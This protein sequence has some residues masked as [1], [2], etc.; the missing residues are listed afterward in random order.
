M[1]MMYTGPLRLVRAFLLSATCVALSLAA[2]LVG[3][4][5]GEPGVPLA[6]ALGLLMATVLMTLILAILSGRRWTV[7]RT[8]V[9]LVLGQVGL[10]AIFTALLGSPHQHGSAPLGGGALMV[11]AHGVAA[12]LLGVGIVVNDSALHIYYCVASSVLGLG[13]TVLLPWRL[14]AL[15]PTVN[16]VAAVRSEDHI[17]LLTNHLRPRILTDLALV[18][19]LSRRGP[20]AL[21]LVP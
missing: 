12:L 8:L 4:G 21:A 10:N 15:I 7:G 16:A 9:A 20:P 17:G 13:I 11:L 1:I 14:A 6:A 19:C 3:A 2:H 5:S 18:Q